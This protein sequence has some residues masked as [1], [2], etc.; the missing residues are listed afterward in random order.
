MTG[1]NEGTNS[2]RGFLPWWVWVVVAME[3]AVPTA[4]GVATWR[5]PAA[6]IAGADDVTYTILLYVTRNLTTALGLLLA[7][8]LRSHTAIF[9][10]IIVRMATDAADM[11]NAS[12]NGAGSSVVESIPYLFV[13]LIVVPFLAQI[14]LWKHIRAHASSEAR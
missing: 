4:F 11:I 2:S 1:S 10:L 5:D 7:V 6:Y 3:I 8:L 12:V 9:I 13:L 14:W